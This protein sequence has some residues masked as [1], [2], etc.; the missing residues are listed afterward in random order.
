MKIKITGIDE[1]ID[2]VSNLERNTVQQ[3]GNSLYEM[4]KSKVPEIENE[5]DNFSVTYINGSVKPDLT[6]LSKQLQDKINSTNFHTE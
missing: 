6:R 1:A 4:I 3:A 2:A 5:K